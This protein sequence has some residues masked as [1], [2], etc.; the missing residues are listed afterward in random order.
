MPMIYVRKL[1]RRKFIRNPRAYFDLFQEGSQDLMFG[2]SVYIPPDAQP[3]FYFDKMKLYWKLGD[4]SS[5]FSVVDAAHTAGI[6]DEEKA[7]ALIELWELEKEGLEG[8]EDLDLADVESITLQTIADYYGD[9]PDIDDDL[10]T[11]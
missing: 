3:Q 5:W 1:R 6:I 9:V 10:E 2:G 8:D 11:K 7:S 4:K